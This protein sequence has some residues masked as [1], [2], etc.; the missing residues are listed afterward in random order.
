MGFSIVA[1]QLAKDF[2]RHHDAPNEHWTNIT[3][4]QLYEKSGPNTVFQ[5]NG[6]K[7]REILL[8]S[9]K[10]WNPRVIFSFQLHVEPCGNGY[11]L[12][13]SFAKMPDV[14]LLYRSSMTALGTKETPGWLGYI[15]PS[16]SEEFLKQC[17]E[18]MSTTRKSV[19]AI[20]FDKDRTKRQDDALYTDGFHCLAT[21]KTKGMI[22]FYPSL[23]KKM[24]KF[25]GVIRGSDWE[26][27]RAIR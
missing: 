12:E 3:E 7:V 13:D 9:A 6:E 1:G 10:Y 16:A 4:G 19:T 26:T 11:I 25:G 8:T 22:F 24:G 27:R 5:T 2:A 20:D 15:K 23:L 14:V 18:A 21:D 17:E